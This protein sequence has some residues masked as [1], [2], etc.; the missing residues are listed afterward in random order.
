MTTKNEEDL[1]DRLR[2]GEE[3]A[4]R[5]LWN[6]HRREV[7]RYLLAKKA[8]GR[9]AE[10]AEEILQD[11]F[12]RAFRSASMFEGR[13]DLRTW[14]FSIAQNAAVDFYRS[15]RNRYSVAADVDCDPPACHEPEVA[16]GTPDA[17]PALTLLLER[18]Q[19]DQ[20]RRGFAKLNE[21][22]QAVITHRAVEELSTTET[23]RM[24]ERSESAVKMLLFRA[25]RS[26][27][28]LLKNDPY[29]AEGGDEKEVAP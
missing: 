13:C 5:Q 9:C 26:L 11:V 16:Y 3:K 22:Y 24:M 28:A 19:S 18:E 6:R 21:E 4:Q 23:A 29:F 15:S 12:F 14:L 10:D 17:A 1:L 27:A 20:L 8:R 25:S 7:Y 2:K